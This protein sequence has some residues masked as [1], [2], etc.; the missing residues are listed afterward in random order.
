MELDPFRIDLG[1][2]AS[3]SG[4]SRLPESFSPRCR[5]VLCAVAL[6]VVR[7]QETQPA[8]RKITPVKILTMLPMKRQLSS[9][10][11]APAD[12]SCGPLAR[13]AKHNASFVLVVSGSLKAESTKKF[14][15]IVYDLLIKAIELGSFALLEFGVRPIGL[16]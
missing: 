8:I 3:P 6:V 11:G 10:T 9:R 12:A 1:V 13:Y 4:K 14:I 15:E 16:K 7:L 5:S 2:P